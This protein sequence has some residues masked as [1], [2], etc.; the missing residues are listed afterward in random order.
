MLSGFNF[1]DMVSAFIVLFAVIDI[2]GSIPIIISLREKGRD[3][4]AIKATLYSGALLVGFFYAGHLLLSLF[5]VDIES[6]AIAGAL[7]IFL[8]ALEMILD[9]EIFKNTGPIKEATLVP[10]VFPLLAG[11]GA[12]TTLLS[13]RAEYASINIMIALALNMVWVYVVLRLTKKIERMLGKGGIYVI[14][15]F[16][17]IILLA[18]AVKLFTANITTLI[19][20]LQRANA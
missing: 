7:I 10:L 3:V 15:K 5:R 14:R 6:F 11:A 1:Q 12:F 20:F 19:A 17:G 18:I 2:I 8:M 16:F 4:N 13:L 9:V